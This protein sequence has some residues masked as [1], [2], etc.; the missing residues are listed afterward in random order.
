MAQGSRSQIDIVRAARDND[1]FRRVVLTGEYEQ[2]VVMTIPPGGEIGEEVHDDTDQD[3]EEQ[4]HDHDAGKSL[5]APSVTGQLPQAPRWP[6]HTCAAERGRACQAPLR[7]N[8]GVAPGR[9][10][11]CRRSRPRGCS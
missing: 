8:P 10:T 4:Q 2:V 11:G 1:A 7:G 3:G 9:A 5:A 6:A